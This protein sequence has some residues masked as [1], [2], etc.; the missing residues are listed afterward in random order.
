M[1]RAIESENTL[2]FYNEGMDIIIEFPTEPD[3][4]LVESVKQ[5]VKQSEDYAYVDQVQRI[6][7]KLDEDMLRY[8]LYTIRQRRF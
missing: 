6:V 4:E 3:K 1:I 2:A 5:I 7:D 8:S